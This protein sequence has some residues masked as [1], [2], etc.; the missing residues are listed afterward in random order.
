M[1][2]AGCLGFAP[3]AYRFVDMP[4]VGAFVTNPI[5]FLPRTPAHGWRYFDFPGGFLLH[6]GFP[7]VGINPVVRRYA[8]HWSRSAKPVIAHLLA[9]NADEAAAMARRLEAVEGVIGVEI[10]FAS[11]TDSER[12]ADC[13]LAAR[14]ELSVIAQLPFERSLELAAV[15]IQAGAWAVSLAAPRGAL[16]AQDGTSI[17]GRLYGPA[18]LPM[19]IRLVEQL[20]T[21]NIPTIGA[22]GI[23]TQGDIQ[24]MLAAGAIAV[25]LDSVL[26]RGFGLSRSA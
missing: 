4:L 20:K 7:N 18:I 15:A 10:G 6:T 14:G 24:A 13:I 3:D 11:D 19:A 26:W 22:G 21:R 2:A 9:R 16:Y 23:Y 17:R 8:R 5:S 12:V 25:Q 1:N